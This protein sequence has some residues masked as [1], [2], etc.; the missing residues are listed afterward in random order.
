MI[1]I[2]ESIRNAQAEVVATAAVNGSIVIKSG[3]G[4]ELCTVALGATP[5]SA[6][7]GGAVALAAPVSGTVSATGTAVY[8]ELY[9]STTDLILSG[10]C[11]I[12]AGDLVLTDT[13]MGIGDTVNITDFT[14]VAPE[15]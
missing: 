11:A 7:A 14:Y 6:A 9:S 5:F 3:T 13:A 8:F 4:Q 12:D 2:A 1:S 10:S 15:A